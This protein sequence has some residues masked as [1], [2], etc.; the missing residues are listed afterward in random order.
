MKKI[1]QQYYTNLFLTDRLFMALAC[2]VLLFILKFFFSWLGE[3]P[4]IATGVIFVLLILDVF[5][6]YRNKSG[7]E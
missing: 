1:F 3:I 7:I 5:I 6:L 2:C 4:E